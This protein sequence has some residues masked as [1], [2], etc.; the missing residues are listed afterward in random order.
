MARPTSTVATRSPSQ[1]HCIIVVGTAHTCANTRCHT[2]QARTRIPPMPCTNIALLHSCGTAKTRTNT[3]CHW[4]QACTH[5][6]LR[7]LHSVQ[8]LRCG[9]KTVTFSPST[10]YGAAL[11]MPPQDAMRL[12]C[13]HPVRGLRGPTSVTYY[14]SDCQCLH[15]TLHCIIVVGVAHTCAQHTGTRGLRLHRGCM[16]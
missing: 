3:Q 4:V 5:T 9:P 12:R 11:A 14:I 2:V 10:K 7:C 1:L 15:T 16:T 13:L 8:G 6:C